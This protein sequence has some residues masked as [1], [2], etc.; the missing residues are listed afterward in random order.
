MC[1]GFSLLPRVYRRKKKDKL[2][3]ELLNKKEPALD[4]LDS[5]DLKQGQGHG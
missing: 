1:P 4:N 5:A 3:R 2:K